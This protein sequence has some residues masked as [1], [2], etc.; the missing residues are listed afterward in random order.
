MRNPLVSVALILFVA[1]ACGS[2]AAPAKEP[3]ATTTATGGDLDYA[4]VCAGV[5]PENQARC[6]MGGWTQ[7]VED[8]EGGV[9]LHLKTSAPAP[10]EAQK[11]ARC[12]RAWMAHDPANAMPR[13]PLGAP[14]IVITAKAGGA[15]TDLFLVASKPE[16]TQEVRKRSHAAMGN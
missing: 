15:G 5:A 2:P 10:E 1:A 3:A 4:Q 16:D 11:R 7:S 8:V 9:V 14:G 12:H 13:C 6:P